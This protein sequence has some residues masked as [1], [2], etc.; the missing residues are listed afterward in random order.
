MAS[1][2]FNLSDT[3]VEGTGAEVV[4]YSLEIPS[5]NGC[6]DCTVS[7]RLWYQAMP[8]RWV[9]PM[10]EVETDAIAEFE[11]M[12]WD[13]AAPELVVEKST[14][15]ST[16]SLNPLA[17]SSW[18]VYPNPT[19]D[20]R[21]FV[22]F[23]QD[24]RGTVYEVFNLGGQRVMAGPISQGSSVWSL[25]LPDAYGAYVVHFHGEDG[26]QSIHRILRK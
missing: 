9:A 21:V 14:S 19:E 15:L 1:G 24:F 16:T 6:E 5:L 7:A 4:H 8:P 2:D 11:S 10:F 20:G 3:G 25:N 12:Y 13:Y 26:K 23:P 22:E 18:K 17:L